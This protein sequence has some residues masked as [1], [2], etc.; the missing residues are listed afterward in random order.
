MVSDILNT[1]NDAI[2]GYVARSITE[3]RINLNED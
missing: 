3:E 2:G 1:D